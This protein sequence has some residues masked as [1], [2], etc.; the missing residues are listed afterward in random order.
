MGG[1]GPTIYYGDYMNTDGG[2]IAVEVVY[3]CF[4]RPVSSTAVDNRRI[5]KT[6]KR[7][8]RTRTRKLAAERAGSRRATG[9]EQTCVP[10]HAEPR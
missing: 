5:G 1:N 3:D 4:E 8:A 2:G 10:E 9:G 7:A 6:A